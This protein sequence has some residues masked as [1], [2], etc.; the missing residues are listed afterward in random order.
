MVVGWHHRRSLRN[1]SHS[2]AVGGASVKRM[3]GKMMVSRTEVLAIR[4]GDSWVSFEVRRRGSCTTS[5]TVHSDHP[6]R[7]LRRARFEPHCPK[8]STR[9]RCWIIPLILTLEGT[10]LVPPKSGPSRTE[11]TTHPHVFREDHRTGN[12]KRWGERSR[13]GPG[14]SR[15]FWDGSSACQGGWEKQTRSSVD[16][17]VIR[18]TQGGY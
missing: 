11:L 4:G 15:G 9:I 13:V 5:R 10:T 18:L 14:N 17:L 12:T 2:R 8:P 6:T 7:A 16:D 1:G 3:D